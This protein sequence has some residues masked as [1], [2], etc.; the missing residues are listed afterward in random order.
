MTIDELKSALD[1]HRDNDAAKAMAAYMKG[2]FEFFGIKQPVR[3]ALSAE[4]IKANKKLEEKQVLRLAD[5]LWKMSER[6]AQ[7]IAMELL[8]AAR[9]SRTEKSVTFYLDL[10]TRKSWWD[11]VDFIATRLIGE[12]Y[13]G[14]RRPRVMLKWVKSENTWQNRTAILFQLNYKDKTDKELLFETLTALKHK[15]EFFI[16]K[17]IGWSLRQYYRTDPDAVN[18]FVEESGITGLAKREALKHT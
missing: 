16:Q 2:H 3:K 5:Q 18:D 10:V 9:K 8:Y 15:K 6:E 1:F 14:E 4:F 13:Q 12:S 11:T 7:Y 17:A